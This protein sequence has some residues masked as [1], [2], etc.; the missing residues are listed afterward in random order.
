MENFDFLPKFQILV[1]FMPIYIPTYLSNVDTLKIEYLLPWYTL[2]ILFINFLYIFTN[3]YKCS[4]MPFIHCCNVLFHDL[5]N[6]FIVP[7]KLGHNLLEDLPMLFRVV[8]GEG[9]VGYQQLQVGS[10]ACE[11]FCSAW[12]PL[13]SRYPVIPPL[14]RHALRTPFS[15]LRFS[16]CV[17]QSLS[18]A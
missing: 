3:R 13:C 5:G 6:L 16:T 7:R 14:R 4:L 17:S 9:R 10:Q 18:R 15:N 1:C 11:M 8:I 2:K 12:A